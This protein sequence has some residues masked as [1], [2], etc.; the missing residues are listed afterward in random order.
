MARRAA[1]GHL[2]DGSEHFARFIF[3]DSRAHDFY[4][5]WEQACSLT[6]AVLR[7]EAERDPLNAELTALIGELSTRSP[8]FRKDWA[9]HD[10]HENRTGRKIYRSPIEGEL[11]L[12]RRHWQWFVGA[13]IAGS[14]REIGLADV[15]CERPLT[16]LLRSPCGIALIP[17][18]RVQNDGESRI[19][20]SLH[21]VVHTHWFGSRAS[22]HHRCRTSAASC[23]GRALLAAGETSRVEVVSRLGRE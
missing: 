12:P 22:A 20:D 15:G 11:K 21:E 7:Y 13:E 1:R 14:E 10:V 18:D 16:N 17:V 9:D 8:Q 4:A 19:A 2:P 3:L 5:D 23:D 6:A